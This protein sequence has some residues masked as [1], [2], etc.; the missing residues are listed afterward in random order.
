[1]LFRSIREEVQEN[2]RNNVRAH[3]PF[4]RSVA[5]YTEASNLIY[6]K[7][8][9]TSFYL[10]CDARLKWVKIYSDLLIK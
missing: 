2:D 4:K 10:K 9:I 5:F 6:T 3:N 7:K 8:Q 1:M